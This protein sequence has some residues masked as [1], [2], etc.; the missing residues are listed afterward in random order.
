MALLP[1]SALSDLSDHTRAP[2]R[3][4]P[5]LDSNMG[6]V[7]VL[8]CQVLL[9]RKHHFPLRTPLPAF[10][11]PLG[12]F[13]SWLGDISKRRPVGLF[14]FGLANPF[15]ARG[16]PRLIHRPATNPRF[17]FHPTPLIG[18]RGLNNSRPLPER[19][20]NRNVCLTTNSGTKRHL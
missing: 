11:G 9:S 17:R 18:K 16:W 8:L 5:L 19:E 10:Q 1:S 14:V 20:D 13:L 6:S 3:W 2:S 4:T 12:Q 15:P 7:P